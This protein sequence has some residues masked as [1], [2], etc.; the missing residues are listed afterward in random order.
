MLENLL[1]KIVNIERKYG[2]YGIQET[3]VR[4]TANGERNI[5]CEQ[6]SE[7]GVRERPQIRS[8]RMHVE[9]KQEIA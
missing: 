4:R 8:S 2:K 9:D 6:E 7:D 3:S 1:R 5:G